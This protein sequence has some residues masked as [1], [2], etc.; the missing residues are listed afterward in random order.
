MTKILYWTPRI[1]A[2]LFIGFISLFALDVFGEGLSIWRTAGALLIH[3]IP[4]LVLAIATAIAWKSELSGG[5]IFLLLGL[6]FTVAFHTYTHL[7]TF[8]II[9][10]PA[11]LIGGLFLLNRI[12][13]NRWQQ[14]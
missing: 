2:V 11:L 14:G 13:R 5:I 7:L 4:S 9:S 6:L 8:L 10:L 3:L 12:K 1:L